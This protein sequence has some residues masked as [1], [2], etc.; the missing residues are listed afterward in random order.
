[1]GETKPGVKMQKWNKRQVWKARI[2][3]K[4]LGLED[5]W[6]ADIWA[7]L[8]SLCLQASESWGAEE[9]PVRL[10]QGHRWVKFGGWWHM[11]LSFKYIYFFILVKTTSIWNTP[12]GT[13]SQ[14]CGMSVVEIKWPP[15]DLANAT[16]ENK[17]MMLCRPSVY[18]NI[19]RWQAITFQNHG[20]R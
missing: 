16:V 9:L 17:H 10:C 20:Q 15:R 14:T 2:N 13:K 5:L 4:G 7:F 11:C 12:K 18:A 1:M 3:S 19:L 6:K 8:P